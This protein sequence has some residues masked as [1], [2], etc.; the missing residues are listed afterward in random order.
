[1]DKTY[2]L[3][4]VIPVFN[5]ANTIGDLVKQLAN[6]SIEGGYE[7]ILVNDSSKDNSREI[8]ENLIKTTPIPV[9]LV[10]LSRNFSEHNAVMAGLRYA[11]GEYVINID[12]DFQNPPSEVVK[13][14]NYARKAGKDIIYTYYKKKQHTAWRNF[15]SWLTNKAADILLDKPHG[16]YLSSFRCM[17]AFLVEQICQ[18]EGPF[19]YIDGL[20]LQITQNI[21]QLEVVHAPRAEGKSSYTLQKLVRLWLNMFVNFSI[22]P[23][24]VSTLLGFLMSLIG[25]VF[26]LTVIVE[27]YTIGTPLGYGSLVCA[28][29]IFSGVQLV[30]LGLIGEYVGRIYLTANKRPQ[31]VVRNVVRQEK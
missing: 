25:L 15:G 21:G 9:T 3:S 16:L 30:S 10:D 14:F 6:L 1:M 13:L 8:C 20:I 4:I 27:H 18:Y 7:I 23:L 17:S 5:S 11:R 26:A 2:A 19:P 28:V 31:F 12:D 22:L 24:R 29:L